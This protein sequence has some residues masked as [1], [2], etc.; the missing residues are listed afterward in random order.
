MFSAFFSATVRPTVLET[1]LNENYDRFPYIM[2]FYR[3]RKFSKIDRKFQKTC[4]CFFSE[5]CY[6]YKSQCVAHGWISKTVRIAPF[7]GTLYY[8]RWVLPK[9]IAGIKAFAAVPAAN[10]C[11]EWV[12]LVA[13]PATCMLRYI[14]YAT[15]TR[16]H[17]R[18]SAVSRHRAVGFYP[19][20]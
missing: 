1:M 7:D 6:T 2:A 18:A 19:R 13:L 4:F 16:L 9:V 5:P 15:G 11:R 3:I 20:S 17:L 8:Y 10:H 14:S 12:R